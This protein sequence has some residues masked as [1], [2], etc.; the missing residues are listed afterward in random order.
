MSRGKTETGAGQE[1][2]PRPLGGGA[3]RAGTAVCGPD[4]AQVSLPAGER[5]FLCTVC[6]LVRHVVCSQ[7]VESVVCSLVVVVSFPR[8]LP[9]KD[10]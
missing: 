3:A 4:P 1:G 9:N 8:L 10:I 5:I 2:W 6:C 7:R